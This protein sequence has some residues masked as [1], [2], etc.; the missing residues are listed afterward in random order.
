MEKITYRSILKERL[1]TQ[2]LVSTLISRFGDSLD[3]IAYSWIMYEV[4]ENASLIAFIMALNYIPTICF[5]PFLAVLVERMEKKKVLAF[6]SMGR[7]AIV[8]CTVFLYLTGNIT[9]IYLMAATLLTSTLEALSLPA[10]NAFVPKLISM[11]KMTAAKSLSASTT[12]LVE[13]VGTSLAGSVIAFLGAHTA[14]FIDAATF[15]ISAFLTL[16]IPLREKRESAAITL[17]DYKKDLVGGFR[18]LTSHKILMGIIAIGMSMNMINVPF[19]SFQS[20]FVADYLKLDAQ[21]LSAFSVAMMTGMLLGSLSSPKLAEKVGVRKGI[22]I[23]GMLF[24]PVYLIET[25]L[26]LY[27]LPV[28]VIYLASIIGFFLMGLGFGLVSVLFSTVFVRLV[29]QEYM[30]RVSGITNALLMAMMPVM[31]LVCSLLAVFLKVNSIFFIVAVCNIFMY[32]YVARANVFRVL[33]SE[34]KGEK[35]R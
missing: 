32:L 16:T 22:V 2:H 27:Q 28:P 8:L 10:G 29:Q 35:E 26:P 20:I 6:T 11:D 9:S 19:S 34:S 15:V 13:L 24:S 4:T 7:G 14:L 23:S 21:A 25:F 12:T 33:D 17:A 30:A 18:Y 3:A 5:Q 31:A 1:Y